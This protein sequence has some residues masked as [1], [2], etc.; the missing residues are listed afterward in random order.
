MGKTIVVSAIIMGSYARVLRANKQPQ[1]A[2]EWQKRSAEA[3]RRSAPAHM[4]TIDV[5]E[6][7]AIRR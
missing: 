1:M 4:E 5:E 6:L 7:R 3:A 2:A